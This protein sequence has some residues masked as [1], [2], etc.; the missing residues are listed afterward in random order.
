[1]WR[2]ALLLAVICSSGF[3][4]GSK[5]REVVFSRAPD[6]WFSLTNSDYGFSISFPSE[7]KPIPFSYSPTNFNQIGLVAKPDKF[8]SYAVWVMSFPATNR[9]SKKQ[10]DEFLGSGTKAMLNFGKSSPMG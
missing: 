9:F 4:C 7:P 5:P 1:M 3:G 6:S 8:S 10:T 2:L